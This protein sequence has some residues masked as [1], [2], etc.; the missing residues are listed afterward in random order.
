VHELVAACTHIE[1][2]LLMKDIVCAIKI[3]N[4]VF[5][6]DVDVVVINVSSGCGVCVI[7]I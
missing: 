5:V 7:N 2:L 1:K 6:P 4:F 3:L